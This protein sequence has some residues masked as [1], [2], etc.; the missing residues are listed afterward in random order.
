M[1]E[2]MDLNEI[3]EALEIKEV[4]ERRKGGEKRI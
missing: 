4:L 1:K 2:A 3:K